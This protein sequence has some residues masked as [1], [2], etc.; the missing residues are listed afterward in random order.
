MDLQGRSPDPH[1]QL[2]WLSNNLRQCQSQNKKVIIMGHISPGSNA[3][4][5]S[6]LWQEFFTKK[7]VSILNSYGKTVIGQFFGHIHADDFRFVGDLT[8]PLFLG[9]ALSPVYT[10]NPNFRSVSF[11]DSGIVDMQSWY[12]NL[13]ES[14][15][16]R[17]ADWVTE[18]S[19]K[20]VYGLKGL[21]TKSLL[22]LISSIA[23][24]DD[25]W[26]QYINLRSALIFPR[27]FAYVC[28]MK[29]L[30]NEKYRQCLKDNSD[31]YVHV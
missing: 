28:A 10:N 20:E 31:V 3:Y 7:Y 2:E 14:N 6:L 27:R 21:S 24:D 1:G 11:D 13:L 26:N 19:V 9:G 15:R 5:D 25:L 8:S 22:N 16:K 12:V 23:K 29:E 17:K 18:Y 4:D 30:D